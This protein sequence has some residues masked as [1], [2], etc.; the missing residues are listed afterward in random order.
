MQITLLNT[1]SVLIFLRLFLW[2][3]TRAH[4]PDLVWI[5]KEVIPFLHP[6]KKNVSSLKHAEKELARKNKANVH[7]K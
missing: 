2:L 4:L 1:D 5:Q 6:E 7:R 3:A